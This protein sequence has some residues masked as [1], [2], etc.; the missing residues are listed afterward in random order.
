[1]ISLKYL[2][3]KITCRMWRECIQS[4][5]DMKQPLCTTKK[6]C[7][8]QTMRSVTKAYQTSKGD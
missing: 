5:F 7:P 4:V 1:M 6:D 8:M 3:Y 2:W